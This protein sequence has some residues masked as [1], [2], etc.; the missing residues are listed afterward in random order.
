MEP[1]ETIPDDFLKMYIEP[2]RHFTNAERLLW[3][4]RVESEF[5]QTLPR[6]YRAFAASLTVLQ[7]QSQELAYATQQL[8]NLM[9]DIY[10]EFYGGF[11]QPERKG[12]WEENNRKATQIMRTLNPASKISGEKVSQNMQAL[13]RQNTLLALFMY[14]VESIVEEHP[15]YEFFLYE[16]YLRLVVLATQLNTLVGLT[17][18]QQA[19]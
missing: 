18:K 2:Q 4:A 10:R 19:K 3:H 16:V 11:L 17:E 13:A 8:D 5:R 1:K 14:R 15:E 7:R 12:L 9:F 6:T